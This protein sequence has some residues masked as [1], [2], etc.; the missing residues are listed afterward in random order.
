ME[1][2]DHFG[3]EPGLFVAQIINFLVLAFLFKK[4]LYKP[5]L[6][7]LRDREEKIRRGIEDAERAAKSLEEAINEKDQIIRQTSREAE[8]ILTDTKTTAETMR[9]KILTEAKEEAEKII[10]QARLSA[11]AEIAEMEKQ[12]KS[13]SL[14][15]AGRVLETVIQGLFTN[16]EKKKIMKRSIEQL[17][18]YE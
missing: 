2:L 12:A 1:I 18:R 10:L 6:K 11:R 8:K 17:N 4:F 14:D 15:I 16:D 13:V 5:V 3:F 9:N 7:T